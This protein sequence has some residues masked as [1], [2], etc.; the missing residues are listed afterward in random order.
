MAGHWFG[1]ALEPDLVAPPSCVVILVSLL[2]VVELSP[3]LI[4]LM[5]S[6]VELGSL[7]FVG[8]AEGPLIFLLLIGR[9]AAGFL[10]WERLMSLLFC[11][12]ICTMLSSISRLRLVGWMVG[13]G[14]TLRLFLSPGLTGWLLFSPGLSWMVSGLRVSLTLASI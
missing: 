8:L 9:L 14:E 11:G 5:S 13:G 1:A 2:T 6:F 7:S 12:P 10:T 3:I 4:V